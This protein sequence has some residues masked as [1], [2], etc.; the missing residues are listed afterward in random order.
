[1]GKPHIATASE[2]RRSSGKVLR[3]IA[4]DNQHLIVERDGYRVAAMMP[5]P[6]YAALMR[7]RASAAHRQLLRTLGARAKQQGLTEEALSE[8]AEAAKRQVFAERYR[9]AGTGR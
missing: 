9:N 3:L 4:Q 8:D 5:Y 2:L 7:L 6:E 1:M